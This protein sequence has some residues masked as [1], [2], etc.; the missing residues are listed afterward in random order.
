MKI[1]PSNGDRRPVDITERINRYLAKVP[2][3]IS[4]NEGHNHTYYVACKLVNG[5]ALSE[6]E[7]MNYMRSWN[8]KCQPE[9]S[10]GELLHKVRSAANDDHKDKRGHMLAANGVEFKSSDLKKPSEFKA[11]VSA[12][13]RPKIDPATCIENFLNGFLCSEAD[14]VDRSPITLSDDWS[15]DGILMLETLFNPGE[16]VNFVTEY[17]E[18]ELADGTKKYNPSGYGDTVE[19]DALL[20]EWR[21][22]G[23]PHGDAGVWFRMNALD[24]D[25]IADKNVTNPRLMLIEFDKIPLDLQIRFMA[26]IKLPIAAILTSGGKSIHAWIDAGCASIAEYRE[27]SSRM[28]GILECFGMDQKNKNPGRL[29]RL[30]GV[31]RIHGATGDG[32]QRLLYLNP[33]PNQ[34]AIL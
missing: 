27:T 12:V 6:S 16:L 24:G 23:M 32:I 26:R 34:E 28:L 18:A 5:F 17:K 2:G 31:K 14:L 4:G 21:K 15:K 8:G 29:S 11:P 1:N 10:E 22:D 30:P 20:A 7:A 13:E 33:H 3:A 19:R 9:W 25:G